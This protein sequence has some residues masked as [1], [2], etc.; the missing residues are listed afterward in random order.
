MNPHAEKVDAE[1]T[2]AAL[3][4]WFDDRFVHL[5]ELGEEL[6]SGLGFDE[7]GT[8]E[9]PSAARRGMKAAAAR[10]LAEHPVV[11]GCGLIFAH[12]ALGTDSGRLEW[13]VREDESRFARY[14]FGVVPGADRYYD[15]EQHEWF[16]RSF[17][18]GRSAA[19]GP[20]IDYLGVEMYIMTLTVPAVVGGRRVGAVGTD[21]QIDDLERALLPTLLACDTEI[22]LLSR[23]GNVLL[24]NSVDYLPGDRVAVPPEGTRFEPLSEATDGVHI[25]VREHPVY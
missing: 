15:Y 12:S 23:R 5:A 3:S 24:S 20:F 19:V 18:E 14:S 4:A 2:I 21:I 7:A 1:Q 22:A 8:L 16:T 17:S 11:D 6:I 9:L 10:F 25:L 13:W